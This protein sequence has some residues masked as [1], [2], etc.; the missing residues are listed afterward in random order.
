M[1]KERIRLKKD[2]LCV[3]RVYR[4]TTKTKRGKPLV[5]NVLQT[6]TPINPNKNH[7]SHVTPEKR[8]KKVPRFVQPVGRANLCCIEFVPF[9]LSVGP[10]FTAK[11]NATNAPKENLSINLCVFR[12]VLERT[13]NQI[14]KRKIVLRRVWPVLRA[15]KERIPRPPV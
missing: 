7:A 3:C 2:N 8:P 12:A 1:T 5:K 14:W 13:A 6:I 9:V 4:V 10:V 15:H 11:L